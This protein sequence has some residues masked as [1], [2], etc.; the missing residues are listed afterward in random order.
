MVQKEFE[1]WYVVRSV[2]VGQLV[3]RFE[4]VGGVLQCSVPNKVTYV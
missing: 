3:V 4:A 1:I 2:C